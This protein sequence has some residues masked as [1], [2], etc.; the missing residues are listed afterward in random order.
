MPTDWWL[1]MSAR[2]HDVDERLT[3][4]EW[5]ERVLVGN[6]QGTAILPDGTLWKLERYGRR[7]ISNRMTGEL[8]ETDPDD[9][10]DDGDPLYRLVPLSAEAEETEA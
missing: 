10:S 8:Y 9:D 1:S 7:W 4:D 5:K 2:W 3:F 6:D